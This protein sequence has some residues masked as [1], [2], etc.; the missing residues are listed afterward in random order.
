MTRRV[1][2]VGG[3]GRKAQREGDSGKSDDE[4]RPSKKAARAPLYQ[5]NL[6]VVAPRK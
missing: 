6:A 2:A 1:V 5:S 4:L 3:V